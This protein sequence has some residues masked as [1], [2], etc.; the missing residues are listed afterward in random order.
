M[1]NHYIKAIIFDLGNVL[2]DFDHTIAANRI[3]HFCDKSPQE[4]FNLFFDSGLTKLFEEGKIKPFDFFLKVK[5]MLNLR[6]NYENF[7]SIW[8]EIF[9]LS[10]KNRQVYSLIN[11]LKSHYK[12]AL[13]T[14]INVLHFDYL[15]RNFFV[16]GVFHKVFTSFE[17]GS[18]KPDIAVYK[19]ILEALEVLPEN[20][21]YTDDRIEL[22]ESAKSLGIRGFVFQGIE[23]LKQDLRNSGIEIN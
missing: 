15:K 20:A 1:N 8:N 4:I 6:L 2:V 12:T 7:V 14:N 19:K 10:A 18:I 21:F 23:K 22:V 17:L 5:E 11:D 9:F 16:F 13:I 3:S